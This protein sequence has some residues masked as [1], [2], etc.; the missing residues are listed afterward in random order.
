MEPLHQENR[1]QVLGE[2]VE[3]LQIS[4]RLLV[5]QGGRGQGQEQH[6]CV[7]AFLSADRNMESGERN[8]M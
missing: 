6:G 8:V 5:L 7:G 3:L 4:L 1:W 2:K